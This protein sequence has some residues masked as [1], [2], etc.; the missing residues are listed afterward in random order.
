[1]C[2]SSRYLLGLS[3]RL[4]DFNRPLLMIWRRLWMGL[5]VCSGVILGVY[6]VI[7]LSWLLCMA[8]GGNC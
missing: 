6:V 7:G 2:R 8:I 3:R 5:V 1:M 4:L